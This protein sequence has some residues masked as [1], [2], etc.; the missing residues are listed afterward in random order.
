MASKIE[1]FR[2]FVDENRFLDETYF[3]ILSVV[4]AFGILQTM[5]A[6]LGTEKPV[7]T[8]ISTSMCPALQVGDILLVRNTDYS[9]VQED[10][11]IVYDV[12]DTVEFSVGG[13]EY[14]LEANATDST[15]S[16]TTSIGE[17]ELVDVHPARVRSQDTA[18]LK[19]NGK[20]PVENGESVVFREDESYQIGNGTLDIGYMTDLPYGNV[21]IVHRVV[22]RTPDY[23]ETMGD[24]NPSQLEFEKRVKP[25]QIHGTVFFEVPR[26]GLVKILAMDFLGYSADQPFVFDATPTC[27]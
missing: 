19:I 22:Q 25:G 26:I 16:V 5:C 23:V 8:V 20:V 1:R 15:P 10:D 12:P 17:V 4:L 7:V 14:L 27:G 24:N 13:E 9:Q 2:E 18:T 3:V 6:G 11:V 21:P